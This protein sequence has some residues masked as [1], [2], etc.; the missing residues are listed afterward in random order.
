[1]KY[2]VIIAAIFLGGC[3]TQQK[4]VDLSRFVEASPRSILVVPVVNNSLDVDA[5]NY[6]LSTLSVPLAEHGYYVFPVNTVKVILEEEGFYEPNRIHDQ[7]AA[8]LASMFNAD[9]ILY[10]TIQRWDA[11]YAILSTTV[12]IQF[13]YRMVDS[14]GEEIWAATETMAYSPQQQNSTGNPLADL[15]VMAVT[16]AVTKA[17]P[18]YMPLARQANN[19]VLLTGRTALP[20]GP[21][22][23]P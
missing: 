19:R 7:D 2:L 1:M 23:H 18:N 14:S 4:P 11:Q 22:A 6:V 10:V 17:A 8:V 12:T 5:S 16:A 21:Y 3:A 9:A 15:I 13:D 20:K